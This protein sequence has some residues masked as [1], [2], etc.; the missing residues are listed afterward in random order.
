MLSSPS[1]KRNMN[2][3]QSWILAGWIFWAPLGE[4]DFQ[5]DF[6]IPEKKTTGIDVFTVKFGAPKR[7]NQGFYF[8][9]WWNNFRHRST[10]CTLQGM[11]T[12]PTWGKGKIIFNSAFLWGY[13]SSLEGITWTSIVYVQVC[14]GFLDAY[15]S[16]WC[17]PKNAFHTW[18]VKLHD[19]LLSTRPF[20]FEKTK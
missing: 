7:K 6:I 20:T 4:I 12:Y 9:N 1:Q 14:L 17:S 8:R 13:V 11:D 15:A 3:F 18:I 10:K 5:I 19:Q 2:Q 16:L